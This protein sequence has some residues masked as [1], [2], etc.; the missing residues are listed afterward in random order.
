[1]LWA[2]VMAGKNPI[3]DFCD[4]T[5]CSVCLESFKDP[6]IIDCGHIFCQA[7]ISQCCEKLN[8]EAACP[9]CREPV[10]QRNFRPNRQLASIVKIAQ[11][12]SLR[13]AKETEGPER[14]CERHQEPLKLFCKDD[15]DPICVVCD[16]S[17]EHKT[18]NVIPK[19][20]AFEEYK[21][22]H[23]RVGKNQVST[24]ISLTC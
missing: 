20:E 13:V 5:T 9:Q 18:H 6:V 4:E 24:N 3:E 12:F 1:M 2:G 21:V 19:E 10:Q 23:W 7:C 17:K 11:K 16:K 14:V 15:Q 22:G 8:T